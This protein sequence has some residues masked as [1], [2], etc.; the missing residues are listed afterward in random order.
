MLLYVEHISVERHLH[1]FFGKLMQ[2]CIFTSY[3]WHPFIRTSVIPETNLNSNFFKELE[4][5]PDF[6]W[7]NLICLSSKKSQAV[8]YDTWDVLHQKIHKPYVFVL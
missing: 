1:I 3:H 6:M 5:N 4:T 2:F 7:E 8:Y